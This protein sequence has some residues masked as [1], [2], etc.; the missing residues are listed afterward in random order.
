M[1]FIDKLLYLIGYVV[2]NK[3]VFVQLK[4]RNLVKSVH[5]RQQ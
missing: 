2:K 1:I 5:I 4:I 3:I